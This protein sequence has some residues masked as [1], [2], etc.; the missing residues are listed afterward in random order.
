MS[1]SPE[2]MLF[3]GRTYTWLFWIYRIHSILS[4]VSADASVWNICSVLYT[5]IVQDILKPI[6]AVLKIVASLSLHN[7]HASVWNHTLIV[8]NILNPL[9]AVLNIVPG[10]CGCQC[11][12]LISVCPWWINNNCGGMDF[13]W[14]STSSSSSPPSS[15]ST[16]RSQ[17]V[18]WSS[19]PEAANMVLSVGCHSMEVMGAVWCLNLATGGPFFCNDTWTEIYS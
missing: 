15:F 19:D 4:L 13:I 2:T 1:P 12:S 5:P 8:L 14:S 9:C 10:I 7:A 3:K 6:C 11:N 17:R 16:A 18:I